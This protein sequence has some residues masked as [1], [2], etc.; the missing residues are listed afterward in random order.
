MLSELSSELTAT[1]GCKLD[2]LAQQT[3]E[4]VGNVCREPSTDV[5]AAYAVAMSWGGQRYSHFRS[6]IEGESK[7]E[8]VKLLKHLRESKLTRAQ[9]FD[10]AKDAAR[11][12]NG[13]GI[14]F[15]TKLLYFF[16]PN[17][18]AYILDQWTAKSVQLLFDAPPVSLSLFGLPA[19]NT[20]GEN[21]ESYCAALEKLGSDL[22]STWSGEQVECAIF[23]KPRGAWRTHVIHQF[24]GSSSVAPALNNPN[25]MANACNSLG[26]N[27]GEYRLGMAIIS[28]H[29]KAVEEGFLLPGD[30]LSLGDYA[31]YRIV[32]QSIGGVSWQYHIQKNGVRVDVFFPK[33]SIS[34]YDKI[35]TA[36]N[37][38]D[39][40]FGGNIKG[41]GAKNGDTRSI[42]INVSGGANA[43]P[44]DWPDIAETSV[45]SMNALFERISPFI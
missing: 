4:S 29:E 32:C 43:K 3:R 9:D 13:L 8:L 17:N 35:R 41:N 22:W 11:Q 21:Y 39:H 18:D 45:D 23:D 15:F 38:D 14:S 1:L 33:P 28:A 36:L 25:P 10:M 26:A 7:E 30:T 2:C 16:R 20:K 12:I 40:D 44:S 6:S 24:S 27:S 34:T 19:A 31:P 42:Y 5:L 37:I